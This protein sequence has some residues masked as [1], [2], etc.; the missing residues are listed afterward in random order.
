MADQGEWVLIQLDEKLAKRSGMPPQVPVPKAEFE[1]LGDRGLTQ[2]EVRKNVQ[3]FATAAAATLRSKD[4]NLAK[5]FDAYLA[6]QTFWQKAE[7]ALAQQD[8]PTAIRLLRTITQVDADDYAAR[9]SLATALLAAQ[10]TE[11]AMKLFAAMGDV[12]SGVPDYHVT[13]G[14]ACLAAERRDDALEQF[15]LAL[16]AQPDFRPAMD[17]LVALGVLVRIYEDPRDAGSLVYVRQDSLISYLES[18]WDETPLSVDEYLLR[19][20]DHENEGRFAAMLAAAERALRAAPENPTSQLTSVRALR[21]L[22][23]L[24][25]A[26]ETARGFIEQSPTSAALEAELAKCLLATNDQAGAEAA[27]DRA[28]AVDPGELTALGMRFPSAPDTDLEQIQQT[29]PALEQYVAE[30]EQSAGAWRALARARSRANAEDASL[31]AYLE[32]LELAPQ[33]DDL[34]GE[35][36]TALV[37]WGR[38]DAVLE[39]AGK[40]E[41]LPRRDW[42]LRWAEAE[43]LLG[44][45]RGMEAR[46]AFMS[47]N[48]DATLHIAVRAR[49]KR[50]L[51]G[52][53]SV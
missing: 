37:R 45:S 24:G 50:A 14:Q 38:F 52:I 46:A 23:E 1:A 20:A 6:K 17:A 40:Q 15:V 27:I 16:E 36:W 39:Q 53:Q 19:A 32:A 2:Q 9:Q 34:R 13:F 3:A 28:L 11:E 22:G 30:H 44:R 10:E 49:A 4:P 21:L 48:A 12:W 41:G 29:L 42:K 51:E 8:M 43:A 5:R 18:Q 7:G 33:D 47:I 25:R 35:Y 26:T 31:E